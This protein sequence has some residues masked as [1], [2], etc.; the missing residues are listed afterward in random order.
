MKL[1]KISIKKLPGINKS[2]SI[3]KLCKGV[4][5]IFGPNGSGKTSLCRLVKISLWEQNKK[6][7][8]DTD[9]SLVWNNNNSTFNTEIFNS[10]KWKSNDLNPL[11]NFPVDSAADCFHISITEMFDSQNKPEDEIAKKIYIEMTGGCDFNSVKEKYRVKSNALKKEAEQYEN[12]LNSKKELEYSEN[13]LAEQQDSIE[14]LKTELLGAKSAVKKLAE[15]SKVENY[16]NN[17]KQ[18]TNLSSQIKAYPKVLEKYTNDKLDILKELNKQILTKEQVINQQNLDINNLKNKISK[19][20]LPENPPN[21]IQIDE[22]ELIISKLRNVSLSMRNANDTYNGA[23]AKLDGIAEELK[24]YNIDLSSIEFFTPENIKVLF[25]FSHKSSILNDEIISLKSRINNTDRELKLIANEV[26]DFDTDKLNQD[27][28]LLN[29]R[30]AI[31]DESP[32]TAEKIIK[33]AVIISSSFTIA[34]FIFAYFYTQLLLIP[35]IGIGFMLAVFVFLLIN[36]K[37]N[38]DVR[39]NLNEKFRQLS[40]NSN[41]NR[42]LALKLLKDFTDRNA[43]QAAT[44]EKLLSLSF[45]KKSDELEIKNKNDEIASLI[46][47]L[48]LNQ[49]FQYIPLELVDLEFN[50]LVQVV[51]SYR[52]KYFNSLELKK[53]Y[54][55]LKEQY[56]GLSTK[57]IEIL[58]ISELEILSLEKLEAT[59][60]GLK[61]DL[62]SHENQTRDLKTK[63]QYLSGIFE[64]LN[65]T[66]KKRGSF[67]LNLEIENVENAEIE[68]NKHLEIL[69]EF[70]TLIQEKRKIEYLQE[71][72][73]EVKPIVGLYKEEDLSE[74]KAKLQ[75]T[76]AK[77]DEIIKKIQETETLIERAEK[78]QKLTECN[79]NTSDS[80]FRLDNA[81]DEVLNNLVSEFIIEK[82]EKQY[83]TNNQPEVMQEAVLLFAKFTNNQ[84]YLKITKTN[85][86]PTFGVLDNNSQKYFSLNELSDGTRVQLFLAVRLA[87]IKSIEKNRVRLPIFFDETLSNTDAGRFKEIAE[88]LFIIAKEDKRQIFYLTSDIN[89]VSKF[90]RIAE[91]FDDDL[92]G[93]VDLAEV[94]NEASY[95]DNLSQIVTKKIIKPDNYTAAEYASKIKVPE[96]NPYLDVNEFHLFYI[97]NDD[98]NTLYKLLSKFGVNKLGA[99]KYLFETNFKMCKQIIAE[100]KFNLIKLRM[101]LIKLYQEEWLK[102]RPKTLTDHSILNKFKLNPKYLEALRSILIENNDKTDVF[103]AILNSN[104]DSRLKRFKTSK[105]QEIIDFLYDNGYIS[106]EEITERYKIRSNIYMKLEKSEA[107]NIFSTEEKLNEIEK[108]DYLYK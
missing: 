91:N 25:N 41:W 13:I 36:S 94:K 86:S 77:H 74:I 20:E 105:K 56:S 16:F 104:R 82:I 30:L 35:F 58:N 5:V 88:T 3:E 68:I 8:E 99:C 52:H 37:K 89:D 64:Q 101:L 107:E 92:M 84:Y 10:V 54:D 66:C 76:A 79:Q 75:T 78:D 53:R 1:D 7:I 9:A 62:Q 24:K 17:E 27:I 48:R 50:S 29:E 33:P 108:I 18:I 45:V 106:N 97:L 44:K 6:T 19:I 34:T 96:F 70:Q 98:L 65:S 14:G 90:N 81:V 55:D 40:G 38:N 42:E 51:D 4:N 59:F 72:L 100:D 21:K 103:L 60:N 71:S 11:P 2:F 83:E 85:N 49:L 15:L 28:N 80:K 57:I 12:L 63:E 43:K 61:K 69:P 95:K 46:N 31:S 93:I 39:D 87:F 23:K 67:L 26:E 32:K 102:G 73:Y 47:R 22:A